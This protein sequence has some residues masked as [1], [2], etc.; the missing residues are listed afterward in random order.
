M[1]ELPS[2]LDTVVAIISFLDIPV[3]PTDQQESKQKNT[4]SDSDDDALPHPDSCIRLAS[5]VHRFKVPVIDPD[6][7][8]S[9]AKSFKTTGTHPKTKTVMLKVSISLWRNIRMDGHIT[10]SFVG[11]NTV[12]YCC[13]PLGR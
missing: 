4:M 9:F 6:Q 13:A 8:L 5:A 11:A 1:C 10:L 12:L 7:R 3:T 2:L